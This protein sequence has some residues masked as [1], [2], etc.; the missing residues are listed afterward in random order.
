MIALDE[1][2]SEV[3]ICSNNLG[4]AH[5]G[6]EIEVGLKDLMQSYVL[7][8]KRLGKLYMLYLNYQL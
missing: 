1:V 8:L 5:I 2:A 4:A 7:N 3:I 6:I